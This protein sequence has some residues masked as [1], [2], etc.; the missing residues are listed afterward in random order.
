VV[1]TDPTALYRLRDGVYAP[2]LLIVAIAE[3]DLFT[4]VNGAGAMHRR[5]AGDMFTDPLPGARDLHLF[6]HVL[7][8]WSEEQVRHL[9]SASFSALTPGGCLV[10]HDT[11]VTR[12]RP[13]RWRSR[14]T[15]CC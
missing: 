6:S 5:L 14:S 10:D 2:D 9:L 11:H 12:P 1:A 15:R 3:L 8:D 13:V 4:Y 7:H